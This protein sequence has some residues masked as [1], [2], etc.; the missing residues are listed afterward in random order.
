MRKVGVLGSVEVWLDGERLPVGPPLQRTLLGLLAVEAGEALS[1]D[2][3]VDALW[4]E[5]LPRDARGLVH[6]YVSRLRKVLRPAEVEIGRRSSG[7]ALEVDPSIVDLH[8]FRALVRAAS[9]PD[10]LRAALALWRGPALSGVAVSDVVARVRVGLDAERLT[11]AEEWAAAALD[12][13]QHREILDELSVIVG[14]HPLREKL[15]ALEVLALY[16]CGRQADALRRYQETRALLAAELGLDPGPDLR[17]LHER[18]LRA[19]PALSAGTRAS[20]AARVRVSLPPDLPDFSGR[21]DELAILCG[22]S[23]VVVVDGMAGVGKTALAVRAA[24]RLGE[25]YPD[26][27]VFVDLHGFTP[28]RSPVEPFTAL[29]SLLRAIGVPSTDIPGELDQRVVAWRNEMA[30]R[31][32]VVMLDNAADSRQVAPLLAG[33]ATCLTMVTSR[34]RLV[35]DGAAQLSL[36]VL[37]REDAR[38]LVERVVGARAV[39]DPAGVAELVELCGRLPLAL[40]MASARL[41]HRPQ[42]IVRDAVTRLGAQRRL[43]AELTAGDRDV[44]SAFAL[45]YEHLEPEHQRVFRLL[46]TNPGNDIDPHAAAA[47]VGMPFHDTLDVLED[48][49]DHH[50][51]EQRDR[52]RYTFHDLVR[53]YARSLGT[54]EPVERLL[55][56]YLHVAHLAADLIQPGRRAI[57]PKIAHVPTDVPA[58]RDHATAMTWFSAERE[59]L[60][61]AARY[62][63]SARLDRHTCAF[64][65]EIGHSLIVGQHLDEL[66]LVQQPA[67]AAARRIGDPA[68][69]MASLYH[70]TMVGYSRCRYREAMDTGAR[71]L[72]VARASGDAARESDALV[73]LGMLAH[74]LG[75]F[76]EALAHYRSALPI[77]ERTN[78]HR[79][80]AICVANTGRVHLALGAP[81]AALVEL[82]NAL[83]RS[84]DIDEQSEEASVL[85]GLGAAHSLLGDHDRALALL[86]EGLAL[87]SEIGNHHYVMRGLVK[88]ADGMRRANRLEEAREFASRAFAALSHGVNQDHLSTA[89]NVLGCIEYAAGQVD[90]AVHHHREALAIASRIE[91]RI[92]EARAH[93]GLA[94]ALDGRE[95]AGVHRDRAVDLCTSMGA[96]DPLT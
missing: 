62:A 72:A 67:P 71:T 78:A 84:R 87:A 15:V 17:E 43:L 3:L 82:E 57:A 13:G 30:A 63:A 65:R 32:A 40:R 4:G 77:Q 91:Y 66:V 2:R 47:L 5:A 89:H 93:A 46:G 45:S 44:V 96:A 33:S 85:C 22:A 29:D 54:E 92:E 37:P 38:A 28:G 80:A 49:L 60:V 8:R 81:A 23:T 21:A 74:R 64:P 10:D 31:R 42:W 7:Y 6:G 86:D 59:N 70:L 53:E 79:Q 39:A 61:A 56:Y 19:D 88:T 52:G 36:D 41:A 75:R 24:H 9:G 16:R 83:R 95:Q 68:A 26:A 34:R 55:D 27:R 35:L 73:V 1:V 94:R 14:A 25:R 11:V 69:E 48:L 18:I 50:L 90:A 58:L 12:G 51:L 20:P 76:D